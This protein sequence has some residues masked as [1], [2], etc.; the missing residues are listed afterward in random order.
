MLVCFL[1]LTCLKFDFSAFTVIF[2][3]WNAVDFFFVCDY[4]SVNLVIFYESLI[5]NPGKTLGQPKRHLLTTGWSVF[6]STK[7]LLAGDSVLFIRYTNTF[8]I[9]ST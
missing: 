3:P 7:R 1:L 6:V 4:C 2:Y 9:E 5:L 8:N